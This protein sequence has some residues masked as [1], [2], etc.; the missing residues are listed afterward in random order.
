M[1]VAYLHAA[2]CLASMEAA[3][4]STPVDAQRLS[5]SLMEAVELTYAD[6]GGLLGKIVSMLAGGVDQLRYLA[7]TSKTATSSRTTA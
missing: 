4:D 3:K 1:A 7:F 5:G 2:C 6:A